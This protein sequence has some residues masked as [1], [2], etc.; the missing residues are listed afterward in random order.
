MG[1]LSVYGG[2]STINMKSSAQSSKNRNERLDSS[3]RLFV[4]CHQQLNGRLA[5]K[6]ELIVIGA[7]P[8]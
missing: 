3:N 6:T 8:Q 5:L 7:H 4:C 2:S 1:D